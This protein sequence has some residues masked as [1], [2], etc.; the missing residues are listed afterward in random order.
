MYNVSVSQITYLVNSGKYITGRMQTNR[1]T[2]I[3]PIK[4]FPRNILLSKKVI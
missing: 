3:D 1:N 4:S 2:N